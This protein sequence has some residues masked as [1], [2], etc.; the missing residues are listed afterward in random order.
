MCFPTYSFKYLVAVVLNDG[1]EPDILSRIAQATAA[2]TKLKAIWKG[3]NI[4]VESQAN[5]FHISVCL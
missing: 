1:S 3:N 4:S 5:H 2:L